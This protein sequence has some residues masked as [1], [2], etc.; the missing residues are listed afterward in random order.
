MIHKVEVNIL[1]CS[2]LDIMKE[3]WQTKIKNKI[4]NGI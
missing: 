1:Y 4:K 2:Q 3:S